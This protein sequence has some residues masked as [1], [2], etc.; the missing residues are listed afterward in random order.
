[1]DR[2]VLL[3]NKSEEVLEIIT[4]K[5]AI[6]KIFRQ[7][8]QKPFQY[9]DFYKIPTVNGHFELPTAIVLDEYKNVPYKK[10]S[11]TKENLLKRDDFACQYCGVN[12]NRN[13]LTMDHVFP[14]SRG[15]KR[16]WKNIVAC[17]R[18][19]N[20]KKDKRTPKEAGM[21]LNKKPI[22]PNMLIMLTLESD[23]KHR[24]AWKRWIDY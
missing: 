16:V 10:V 5:E 23:R 24:E 12:L 18:K 1:M 3:L 2:K 15:G 19:C 11:L 13:T 8:A 14:D 9:D 17:C 22:V 6:K 21:E 20:N 4:P 7:V